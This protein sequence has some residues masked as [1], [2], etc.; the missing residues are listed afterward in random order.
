MA[1]MQGILQNSRG[2]N[3]ATKTQKNKSWQLQEA[4]AMLSEVIKASEL[5]PQTITVWGKETAVILSFDEYKKLVKPKQTLYEF[6]QNSPLGNF[7]LEL[8]ERLPESM[9]EIGL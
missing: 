3:M 8:P 9:R 6:I 7:G 5:K 2:K 4:K 1:R